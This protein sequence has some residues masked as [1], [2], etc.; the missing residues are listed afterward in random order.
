MHPA[1]ALLLAAALGRAAGCD[2]AWTKNGARCG[3][4]GDGSRCWEECCGTRAV[5]AP[6]AQPASAGAFAC[7]ACQAHGHPP[8]QCRCGV[9]GSGMLGCKNSCGANARYGRYACTPAPAPPPRPPAPPP[10]NRTEPSPRCAGTLPAA[11]DP[12][13]DLVALHYDCAADPDD[14]ASSV[15][16]RTMLEG[17]YGTAWV[18]GHVLPVIG[19]YGRN[20]NYRET[21]C[22]RVAQ[23]VWGDATGYL[24]AS[25]LLGRDSL[26]LA[27][28]GAYVAWAAAI[29]AGGQVYVKEGGQ[30]DFTRLVVTRLERQWAGAGK[31]VHVVQVYTL[32]VPSPLTLRP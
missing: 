11:L 18:R 24:R 21:Q 29:G 17:V 16:D 1:L 13:L 32:R 14:L 19:A 25:K 3:P 8:D 28:E 10:A 9:C 7:D 6:A 23:A 27:V 20:V 15:A 5:Q 26:T 22:E 12:A 2:C 30:S 4:R 31:C